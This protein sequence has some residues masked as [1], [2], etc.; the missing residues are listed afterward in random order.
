MMQLQSCGGTY[1]KQV[2]MDHQA[3]YH[4][5]APL[6]LDLSAPAS[7]VYVQRVFS[8]CGILAAGRR[9]QLKKK[10]EMSVFLKLNNNI[11]S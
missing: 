2:S 6:A 4:S 9:S 7:E 10:L 5:L 11:L 3:V 1:S 8:L